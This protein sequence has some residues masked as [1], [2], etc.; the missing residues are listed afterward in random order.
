MTGGHGPPYD[1]RG[2]REAMPPTAS[3]SSLY[4]PSPMH[5]S[6]PSLHFGRSPPA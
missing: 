2:S 5:R 6:T 1:W 3:P 4:P